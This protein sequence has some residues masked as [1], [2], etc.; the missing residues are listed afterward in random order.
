MEVTTLFSIVL[1][2]I[3]GM[4]CGS[5]SKFENAS[6]HDVSNMTYEVCPAR[7]IHAPI[8]F[9]SYFAVKYSNS[10]ASESLYL[11]F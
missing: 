4:F 3:T 7:A 5:I 1:M 11:S 8:R 2:V 6:L 9:M 10:P